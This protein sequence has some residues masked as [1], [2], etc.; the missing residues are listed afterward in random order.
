[1]RGAYSSVVL[2]SLVACGGDSNGDPPGAGGTLYYPLAVGARWTY[3]VEDTSNQTMSV[4]VQTVE[5]LEDV[6]GTKAGVQ[7][8]RVRTEKRDASNVLTGVTVS[9]QR[10]DGAIIWREQAFDAVNTLESAEIYEPYKLRFDGNAAHTTLGA[11]YTQ[12]YDERIT[13]YVATQTCTAPP[14]STSTRKSD[15]WTVEAV[16]AAITTPAGSYQALKLHKVALSTTGDKVYYFAPDVGKVREEG[17]GQIEVL[18]SY[19]P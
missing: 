3:D 12:T 14:C 5:I 19:E 4:K 7:A 8:Y 18:R 2:M 9:W 10:P 17:S 6:G 15:R 16:N 1:M 11:S 13:Q